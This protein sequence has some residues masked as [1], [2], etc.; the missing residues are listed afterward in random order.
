M[1][2]SLQTTTEAETHVT[3]SQFLFEEQILDNERPMI[4]PAG[5]PRPAV[6][7][8]D[9]NSILQSLGARGSVVG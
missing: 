9:N 2:T 7:N 6:S 8:N 4:Y 5:T 3:E 1:S